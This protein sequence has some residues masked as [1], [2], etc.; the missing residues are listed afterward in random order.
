MK[1]KIPGKM[2]MS[3]YKSG[4]L[5]G[6]ALLLLSLNL[7]AQDEIKKEFHK[8]YTAEKSTKLELNNRYGDIVAETSETNQVVIDVVVTL[9]HPNRERAEKLMGYIDVQFTEGENLI[10]AKTFIDDKFSFT[11]WGGESRRFRIDYKVKMPVW[12][13]L[14]LVNRYGDTDLDDLSGQ[15]EL[16]VKYGSLN[17]SKLTRGN[18]KPINVVSVAYGNCTID[19]AGWLDAYVRYCGSFSVEKGQAFLLDSRYSKV[20]IGTA[21]SVVGE[22]KY[23]NLRIENIGNLVLDAGYTDV[24]VGTLTRKLKLDGGYGGVNIE[25]VPAGF[26]SIDI[27]TDYTGVRVGIDESANFNL[28]GNTRYCGLKYNED[29]FQVKRRI[30]GNTSN[31]ISGIVGKESAP[32]ATVK[33]NSSYGSVKL[34]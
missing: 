34:Y 30:I 12:M 28:E 5:L 20:R 33:V 22:V 7:S 11:G 21:S 19:E 14:N 3:V 8:E 1:T 26:E 9:R 25:R 6:A 18:E 17:V 29:N 16:D 13:D 32:T 4:M 10:S 2:K 15:V 27:D 23:D 31:E 24:N